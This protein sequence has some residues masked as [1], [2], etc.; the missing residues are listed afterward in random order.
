MDSEYLQKLL[1][2]SPDVAKRYKEKIK[3]INNVDPFS[4]QD[5]EV[6]FLVDSFPKIQFVDIMAYLVFTHSFYTKEQIKAYK[7][8]Q[9]YKYLES[10]FVIKLGTKIIKD[11]VV[12]VGKV[13][14]FYDCFS[15][16]VPIVPIREMNWGLPFIS[17]QLPEIQA[18][19][20]DEL[21]TI[22]NEVSALGNT[23]ALMRIVEPFASKL[24]KTNKVHLPTVFNLYEP[25][26]STKSYGELMEISKTISYLVTLEDK[27]AVEEATQRQAESIDW[28][29]QRAGR[30]TASKLRAVCK[31]DHTK[32]ALSLIKSLCYP[33]KLH[34]CTKPILWGIANESNAVEEYRRFMEAENHEDFTIN[35]VGLIIST[36]FPQFGVSPDRIVYCKCCMGGC[37]EV[38]CPYLLHFKN[39]TSIEQYLKLK[40]TCLIKKDRKITLN[41]NHAYYY[42]VQ[43][44]IFVSELQYCDF[45]IWTPNIFFKERILPNFEFW[46][47]NYKIAV[48]FH[49]FIIMPELLGRYFTQREGAGKIQYWCICNGVDDQREMIRCENDRCLIQWF[50]FECVGLSEVP[51]T[52][53]YC[54]QCNL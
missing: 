37:L 12:L 31:T 3:L 43:A 22:L 52:V 45:V 29:K 5:K 35:D 39:I 41:R 10:G 34:N 32:P 38:K 4:L 2:E 17:Q 23:S 9:S 27:I 36:R 54:S 28:F 18:G 53:W 21:V 48:K 40:S 51:D 44:Q 15:T 16:T 7:S 30:I 49:K 24:E 46:E 20:K 42:Q 25:N 8:L 50:H 14:Y 19:T 6:S 47:E 13:S 1:L 26:N 33:T 11:L